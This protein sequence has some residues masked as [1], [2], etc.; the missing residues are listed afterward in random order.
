MAPTANPQVVV[1]GTKECTVC[2]E[3]KPLEAFSPRPRVTKMSW[4]SRCR[5]CQRA[6]HKRW[7]TENPETLKKS[8]R[9]T[10]LKKKYGLDPDLYDAMLFAQDGCCAI[11]RKPSAECRR[12]LDVDHN[13]TT[14]K[15]RGLLC[16]DCNKMVGLAHEQTEIL[17]RAAE[18]LTRFERKK[19]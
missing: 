7:Q 9:A 3:W 17:T 10:H 6:D 13:H 1:D 18:Y 11:C 4:G 8:N 5:I 15:V 16:E 19:Q 14:N 2:H 12:R